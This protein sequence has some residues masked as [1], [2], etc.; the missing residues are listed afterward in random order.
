MRPFPSELSKIMEKISRPVVHWEVTKTVST[1]VER[2]TGGV[3]HRVL[4]QPGG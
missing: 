2:R 1:L 4:A 3:S